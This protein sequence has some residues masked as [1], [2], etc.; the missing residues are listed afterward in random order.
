[1]R[2]PSAV[3]AALFGAYCVFSITTPSIFFGV[4]EPSFRFRNPGRTHHRPA[5][6]LLPPVLRLFSANLC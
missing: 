5:A 1:M 4:R 6:A 2:F 3:G